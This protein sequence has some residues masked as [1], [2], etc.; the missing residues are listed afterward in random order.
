MTDGGLFPAFAG[1]RGQRRGGSDDNH[2][3]A[4][5]EFLERVLTDGAGAI[6]LQGLQPKGWRL[7]IDPGGSVARRA[8]AIRE[9]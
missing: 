1:K 4:Q 7:G 2:G 6:I 9:S 8:F 5:V 3:K